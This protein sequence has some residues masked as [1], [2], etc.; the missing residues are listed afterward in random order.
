M[1]EAP[2]EQQ[3]ELAGA[4]NLTS[5]KRRIRRIPNQSSRS[6]PGTPLNLS[7]R[8]KVNSATAT[9]TSI[10][11]SAW[12]QHSRTPIIRTR[13]NKKTP[14]QKTRARLRGREP[15]PK[16]LLILMSTPEQ[17][18]HYRS[19]SHPAPEPQFKRPHQR[20]QDHLEEGRD[21]G[22]D[23]RTRED[24]SA[25]DFGHRHRVRRSRQRYRGHVLVV[26]ACGR[27]LG[28]AGIRRILQD[29]ADLEKAGEEAT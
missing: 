7:S 5:V 8:A 12:A 9:T 10:P 2:P 1:A 29:A 13:Q 20:L 3:S 4:C 14:R 21:Q 26:S 16:S 15:T 22:P 19:W 23:H 18:A 28:R 6:T 11:S 25:V 17:T 27:R 24:Q